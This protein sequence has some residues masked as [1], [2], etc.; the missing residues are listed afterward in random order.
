MR[1][2]HWNGHDSQGQSDYLGGGKF[3]IFR[4]HKFTFNAK[5]LV[6]GVWVKYPVVATGGSTGSYFTYAPGASVDYRVAHRLSVFGAYE[7]QILPSAPGFVGQPSHGLTP[8]GFSVGVKYRILG[9][10]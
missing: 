5:F 3:A 9:V 10:R 8:H 1:W 4:F 2:L 7:Y 6:G